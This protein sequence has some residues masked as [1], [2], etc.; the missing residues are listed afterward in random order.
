MDKQICNHYKCQIPRLIEED[1][2]ERELE[3]GSAID[4][5]GYL[6]NERGLPLNDYEQRHGSNEDRNVYVCNETFVPFENIQEDYLPRPDFTMLCDEEKSR[7]F[8]PIIV[9]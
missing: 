9:S 6:I 8:G 2:A 5:K 3:K 7:L 4:A 1:K